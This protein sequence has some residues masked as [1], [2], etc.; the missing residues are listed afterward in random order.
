MQALSITTPPAIPTMSQS[1]ITHAR[2]MATYQA[3]L[4]EY[5]R[6]CPRQTAHLAGTLSLFGGLLACVGVTPIM[7]CAGVSK[8]ISGCVAVGGFGGT[9]L[10]VC[11]FQLAN[12]PYEPDHPDR[13]QNYGD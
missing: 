1:D 2:N 3:E 6:S 12:R 9:V 5:E 11:A 10:G 13:P 8:S 4:R 7:M